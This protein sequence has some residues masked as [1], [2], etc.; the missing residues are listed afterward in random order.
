MA[1]FFQKN[2]EPY[3][4]TT[5]TDKTP[6]EKDGSLCLSCHGMMGFFYIATGLLL[7]Y[8]ILF[9]YYK[10]WWKQLPVF[11]ANAFTGWVPATTISVIVPAR[12]EET[13]IAA[14]IH[15]ICRQ[16]YPSH[17]MQ[18]IVV[19]DHSTDKT[20]NIASGIFYEGIEILCIQPALADNHTAPKK[21]AIETGIARA[22]GEL[23]V[24]TDADC[25]MDIHWL[26][27]IA[28]Y[29]YQSKNIFIAAPVKITNDSS[30]LSKFQALDF[31]TM[32]GITGAAVSRHF[33]HMCNGA[34]LAYLKKTF[35]EIDGFKGIDS[36]ASG[37]D[38]LLMNKIAKR[39]PQQLGFLKSADAIVAT[40]PA[41]DWKQFLNQRIRWASKATHYNQANIFLVLL[42]VY[43][44]NLSLL[45]L[46]IT[47]FWQPVALLLF[48]LLCLIKFFIEVFFVKEVAAF[49][50][51]EYLLP[52]LFY[53]QPLHILYIVISGIFGQFKSYE[54]KGRKLK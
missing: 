21:R 46:L 17:L 14:C 19:D 15:S 49:F 16:D 28:A 50:K 22:S 32:Q 31:L 27:T 9:Q 20:F 7:L 6:P 10:S 8:G 12:N 5:N 1:H 53:L 35:D 18:V 44:T 39:Y 24:T 43:L 34:N 36:I 47:A 25:T 23:I 2:F 42:L 51:Q 40:S 52:W 26:E 33:H 45:C 13:N 30:L 3:N 54:W 37:D 41:H 38:M 4:Q 29:H 11:D 48:L